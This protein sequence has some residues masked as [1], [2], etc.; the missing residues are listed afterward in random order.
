MIY[1]LL[2]W[3]IPAIFI[4]WA[5]VEISWMDVPDQLKKFGTT[6]IA[7]ICLGIIWPLTFITMILWFLYCYFIESRNH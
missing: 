3:L 4:V 2:G 5:F 6:Q 7:A 1:V